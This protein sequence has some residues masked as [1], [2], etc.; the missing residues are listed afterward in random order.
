LIYFEPELGAKIDVHLDGTL[1]GLMAKGR[2][3]YVALAMPQLKYNETL[4][5]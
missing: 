2:H 3:K 5:P 4:L 1:V